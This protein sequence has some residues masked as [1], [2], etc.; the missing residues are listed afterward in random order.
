MLPKSKARIAEFRSFKNFDEEAFLSDL[1]TV[2]WD[3]AYVFEEIDDIWSHW[4][5][6]FKNVVDIHA[7]IYTIYFL[8]SSAELEYLHLHLHG[9]A[10]TYQA[11]SK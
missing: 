9:S 5:N 4:E 11:V 6:L 8:Q 2:P 1:R 7:P 3:S 10:V